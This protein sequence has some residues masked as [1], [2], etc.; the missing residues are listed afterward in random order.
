MPKRSKKRKL[1]RRLVWFSILIAAL[2][3]LIII[4]NVNV[5]V[6]FDT[7]A[8]LGLSPSVVSLNAEGKE[9]P[10][11]TF[12]TTASTIP[13][14]S[15]SCTYSLKDV[16]H[17]KTITSTTLAEPPERYE[18][19]V[20]LPL[21]T[22]GEGQVLF[23][24]A[25]NCTMQRRRLCPS[26]GK[27][28]HQTAFAT[29][30]YGLTDEEEQAQA[31]TYAL[32]ENQTDTLAALATKQGY[33]KD[34]VAALEGE[35][36][37]LIGVD[38]DSK[39][40]AAARNTEQAILDLWAQ[41]RY[42]DAYR[43]AKKYQ[44][45]LDKLEET[46]EGHHTRARQAL[47][48]Y[49]ESA[50]ILKNVTNTT[51]TTLLN[52]THEQAFENLMNDNQTYTL[53][54]DDPEKYRPDA[55]RSIA[56]TIKKHLA[57]AEQAMTEAEASRKNT[58][59]NL[60]ATYEPLVN[61]ENET[62]PGLTCD[63]LTDIT[64]AINQTPPDLKHYNDTYCHHENIT[65]FTQAPPRPVA[66]KEREPTPPTTIPP[67]Q[68]E[69]C[70][71]DE[72]KPCNNVNE[73]PVILVHGHSF[74]KSTTPELAFARLGYLQR[75][76]AQDGYINAGTM[77]REARLHTVPRGEWGKPNHP[78]TVRTTYYYLNYYDVG[79]LSFVT[80]KTER[81]ENYAI[82]LK[83]S[84]NT[85]KEKTGSD[86]VILIAH[87]MGGLVAR[88]YLHLFGDED[89]KLL[90]TLGTPNHGV[91]GEI[92]RY[93]TV[94]GAEAECQDMYADSPF[95]KRLNDP[96]KAPD[97]TRI[98]TVAAV[99]CPTETDEEDGHEGDGVVLRES[100]RLD[101]AV[102][103]YVVNGTCT[104]LLQTSLHMDFVNPEEYP[105]T[106]DVI[107]EILRENQG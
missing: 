60:T 54:T 87:S 10:E 94:T 98:Y 104:D 39:A 16:S 66:I 17:N 35:A 31:D 5:K 90:I 56:E 30:T 95:L 43:Q 7:E 61:A 58:S 8:H 74:S 103:N 92:R 48:D 106:Y 41:Q 50:I 67:T 20:T 107:K 27:E 29:V 4:A 69:C 63:T 26:S 40:L 84:I 99:G 22:R 82:R 80:R 11:V 89:V 97:H 77:D 53:L 1:K 70:Y 81:I 72:C 38:L 49:N 88:D 42:T 55:H 37:I 68:E 101:H 59:E 78:V 3:I 44:V 71:K 73:E 13:V 102:E 21:P 75:A 32:L 105:E 47:E 14:C 25:V 36:K 62:W 15:L 86:E 18:D 51:V 46:V 45:S 64:K 12:T 93:C 91:K 76:L 2:A 28:Y 96:D 6:L 83:E 33:T 79:E 23:N 57:A 85:V 24:Y 52:K 19:N 34:V 65:L 100:V 9:K